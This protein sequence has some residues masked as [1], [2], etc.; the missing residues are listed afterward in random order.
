[1]IIS[2]NSV[3]FCVAACSIGTANLLGWFNLLTHELMSASPMLLTFFFPNSQAGSRP[4]QEKAKEASRLWAQG[5]A[6][7]SGNQSTWKLFLP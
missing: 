2:T 7:G 6:T 4:V 5:G 3:F 1:M